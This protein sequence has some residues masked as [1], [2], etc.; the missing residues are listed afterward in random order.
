M[1]LQFA[2]QVNDDCVKVNFYA[3]SETYIVLPGKKSIALK[4][5]TNNP[6]TNKIEIEG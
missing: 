6:E 2:Y 5:I 1:I 4:Q 3:P